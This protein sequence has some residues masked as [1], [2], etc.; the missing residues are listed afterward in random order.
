MRVVMVCLLVTAFAVWYGVQRNRLR[1]ARE[2][3]SAVTERWDNEGGRARSADGNAG[4]AEQPLQG[5]RA[6]L[7]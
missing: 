6:M 4:A 2:Y 7:S 5:D 1:R 3:A